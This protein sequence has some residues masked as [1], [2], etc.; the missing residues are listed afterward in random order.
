M[1]LLADAVLALLLLTV[2]GLLFASA[3]RRPPPVAL[4]GRARDITVAGFPCANDA[5]QVCA[6]LRR[7]EPWG[8]DVA[9]VERHE[10]GRIGLR[11]TFA[12]H[13]VDIDDLGNADGVLLVEVAGDLGASS[14]AVML[15]G[16]QETADALAR[17]FSGGRARVVRRRLSDREAR[18][19]RASVADAPVARP[20]K[21]EVS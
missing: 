16:A 11:G 15:F 4:P 14:S 1:L 7:S 21:E 2:T 13:R 17:A 3:R 6:H 19:L 8:R 10:R 18:A 20:T 5:E 12:G 9:V